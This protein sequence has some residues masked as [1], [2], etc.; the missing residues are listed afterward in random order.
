[1]KKFVVTFLRVWQ[2]FVS[3]LYPPSCRFYPTCSQYAIMAVEKYGPFKG[4]IKAVWR[5][6]RCNP[7]S[8]GGVDYP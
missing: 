8:R 1:M 3:P 7:F 5:V 4:T 2:R 6:L